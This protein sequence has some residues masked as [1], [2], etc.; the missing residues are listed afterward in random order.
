MLVLHEAFSMQS[1]IVGGFLGVLQ[2][3]LKIV[4]L[5]SLYRKQQPNFQLTVDTV[6]PLKSYLPAFMY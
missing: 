5:T 2:V 3:F 6:L 4:R 1:I